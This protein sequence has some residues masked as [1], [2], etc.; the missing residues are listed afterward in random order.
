[1]GCSV[2]V[3]NQRDDEEVLMKHG[4]ITKPDNSHWFPEFPEMRRWLDTLPTWF[5][6]FEAMRIEEEMLDDAFVVRAEMPGIDPDTDADVWIAD[7][8]LHLK[9]ERTMQER[10]ENEG[11]RSEFGYGSFHRAVSIPRGAATDEVKATYK[12]G[13]LEIRVPMRKM[14]TPVEKVQI[15]KG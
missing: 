3:P 6:P 13:V 7:G 11:F 2:E 8:M 12:D 4:T 15:T 9:V 10:T 5:A 1:M 14:D